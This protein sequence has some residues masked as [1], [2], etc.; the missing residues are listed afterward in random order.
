MQTKHIETNKIN[1]G[2]QWWY[3]S[4]IDEYAGKAYKNV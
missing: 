4:L 1:L 3:M 2:G